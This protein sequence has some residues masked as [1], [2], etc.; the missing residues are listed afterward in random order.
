[1]HL[2]LTLYSIPFSV[3]ELPRDLY[4]R[5]P[6]ESPELMFEHEDG[7]YWGY[8]HTTDQF[9]NERLQELGH[10]Y[11]VIEVGYGGA[12]TEDDL[13]AAMREAHIPFVEDRQ[14]K[15]PPMGPIHPFLNL[16]MQATPALTGALGAALGAVLQ[17]RG[18]RHLK[19]RVGDREF[20]ARTVDEIQA[21]MDMASAM[22]QRD[23]RSREERIAA[24]AH[25]FWI[26]R[27][28]PLGS[29]E[30]DWKQAEEIIT[31][32]GIERSSRYLRNPALFRKIDAK[33]PNACYCGLVSGAGL[34]ASCLACPPAPG[35]S[36][37]SL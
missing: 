29:P 6:H 27:G 18:A 24:L 16:V 11:C 9:P 13:I 8:Y 32:S 31:D 22:E 34:A 1:M 14:D 20:E 30:E 19:M 25:R 33:R 5:Q 21:L 7:E 37:F 15:V 2:F 36:P 10:P 28:K 23:Q 26:L 12:D 4:G 17:Q 3:T 35:V